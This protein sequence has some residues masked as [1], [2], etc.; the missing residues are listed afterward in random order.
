MTELTIA[1]RRVVVSIDPT[2]VERGLCY[3]HEDPVRIVL[4]EWD[5]RVF[6]HEVMHIALEP[7]IPG[8]VNFPHPPGTGS[9]TPLN[10]Q[11]IYAIEEAFADLGAWDVLDWCVP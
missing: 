9:V 7:I 5:P 8:G 10:H 1:G 11:I 2:I 6:A 4:Q 3:V